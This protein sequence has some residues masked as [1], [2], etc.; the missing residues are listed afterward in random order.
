[1]KRAFLSFALLT[2]LSCAPD[3]VTSSA[4]NVN[5]PTISGEN[6]FKLLIEFANIPERISTGQGHQRAIDFIAQFLKANHLAYNLDYFEDLTPQ[7]QLKFCNIVGEIKGENENCFVLLASHFDTKNIPHFQGANDGASSTATLLEILKVYSKNKPPI[8]IRFA[9]FDGEECF[10]NYDHFDGLHG[11]RYHA[12][13]LESS[14]DLK[15]CLAMILM[16]L[17]GDKQLQYTL[18]LDTHHVLSKIAQMIAPQH[19]AFYRSA[20]L[21]D[22]IPF[23]EKGVPCIDLIDFNY[24][25][26]NRYWHTSEDTPDKCSP[27]SLEITG[28]L[29]I[30]MVKMLSTHTNKNPQNLQYLKP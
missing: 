2:F 5:T 7:G 24:G 8:T 25:P 3:P 26:N 11:S 4:L 10:Y 23:A 13:K 16:D 27:K 17:I 18:P 21:D 15:N 22:H 19:I 29:V 28:N 30:K 12:K 1:M 6:A 20:I 9:F 14:G